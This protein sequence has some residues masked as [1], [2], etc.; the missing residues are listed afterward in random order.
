MRVK[1]E[2]STTRSF[3]FGF[4]ELRPG[5]AGLGFVVD[6][7]ASR[8]VTDALVHFVTRKIRMMDSKAA[9]SRLGS[10]SWLEVRFCSRAITRLGGTDIKLV[11]QLHST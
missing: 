2:L 10:L 1:I 8:C 3:D 5:Y 7:V 9:H 4:L 6:R 11:P